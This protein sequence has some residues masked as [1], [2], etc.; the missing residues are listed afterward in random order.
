MVFLQDG[1]GSGGRGVKPIPEGMH[2]HLQAPLMCL[3]QQLHCCRAW[4]AKV[5]HG[6]FRNSCEKWL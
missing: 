2:M 4:L 1:A 5:L 3:Q 6:R